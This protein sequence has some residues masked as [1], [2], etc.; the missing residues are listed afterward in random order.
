MRLNALNLDSSGD[1]VNEGHKQQD[2]ERNR[3]VQRTLPRQVSV[4]EIEPVNG[5]Y[6]EREQ[7]EK[8]MDR[9]SSF[10]VEDAPDKHE[11]DEHSGCALL[12]QQVANLERLIR[13]GSDCLRPN[14]RP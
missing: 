13:V 9:R 7:S 8:V 12:S 11:T 6:Q 1:S 10:L 14:Q 4:E 5:C 3:V 2:Q